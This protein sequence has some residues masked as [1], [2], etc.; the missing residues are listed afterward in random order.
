MPAPTEAASPTRKVVQGSC[1]AKAVAKKDRRQRR[2]RAV[3]EARQPRLHPRQDGLAPGAR[4]LLGAGVGREVGRLG[5]RDPVHV[6]AL[7]GGEV[8]EQPPRPGVRRPGRGRLVEATGVG[9]HLGGLPADPLEAQVLDQPD[10]A[11]RVVAGD[12][13][14]PDQGDVSVVRCFGT[15]G[16]L[17]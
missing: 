9:L 13:L 5:G 16:V 10:R 14:A 2:D 17:S 7:L 3:H 15:F 11:A 12:V 1:V 8:A 4:V 6:A